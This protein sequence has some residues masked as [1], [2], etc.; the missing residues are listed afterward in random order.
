MNPCDFAL[1]A[2]IGPFRDSES[3]VEFALNDS[4]FQED[5]QWTVIPHICPGE[6]VTNRGGRI[7]F[8]KPEET[9]D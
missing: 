8:E 9:Q 6:P 1:E 7:L 4:C 5:W 2:S 3:A